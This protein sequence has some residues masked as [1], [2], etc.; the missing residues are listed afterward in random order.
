MANTLE[1]SFFCLDLC[2]RSNTAFLQVADLAVPDN[3]RTLFFRAGRTW[4]QNKTLQQKTL[5]CSFFKKRPK[6]CIAVLYGLTVWRPRYRGNLQ[7]AAEKLQCSFLN[8]SL[9]LTCF[10]LVVATVRTHVS[11]W[12]L[13]QFEHMLQQIPSEATT[14]WTLALDSHQQLC[15][16]QCQ[17]LRKPHLCNPRPKQPA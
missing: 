7:K 15:K 12:L 9:N 1:T 2:R 16:R 3:P 10:C 17:A 5:H 14:R 4:R 8:F 11:V 6:N 13:R